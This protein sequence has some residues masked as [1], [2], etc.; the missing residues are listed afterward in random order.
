MSKVT[1]A[2]LVRI[3]SRS[4]AE[5]ISTTQEVLETE[6]PDRLADF[7]DRMNL[8][9]SIGL[10]NGL[11]EVP[12]FKVR[13]DMVGTFE[14]EELLSVGI[15]KFLDRHERK[16]KWHATHASLDGVENVILMMRAGMA[17]TEMRLERLLLCL[18]KKDDL[19]PAEWAIAR[20]T[21]NK[22]YMTF[23]NFLAL[24]GGAWIDAM[25]LTCPRDD[26]SAKL[27]NFYEAI[28]G[29]IRALDDYRQRIETRRLELTV[30]PEG[31]PPVKP[32]NYFGGDLLGRGPW[33]QFWNALDERAHHFREAA[34]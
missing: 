14:E 32:P 13:A 10:D 26:I 4:E 33:K 2:S 1:I 11:T 3:A 22:A 31:F 5:F 28:D 12:K 24:F 23:R 18:A 21:M 7:F 8:P 20:Q 29:R 15:Q 17:V 6:T 25:V 19:T 9:R 30:Q 27:G 34:S 16:I